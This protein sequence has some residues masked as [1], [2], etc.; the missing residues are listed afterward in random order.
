MRMR[1]DH[2]SYATSHDK[3]ID[4]V[5]R[6]G[7][8]VGAT[9]VDGGIHPGFGTRNFILPLSNGLY[10]EVVCPLDHPAVDSTP[11][12]QM[13][14]KK[15]IEG[16]GWL[17]WVVSTKDISDIE[18]RLGRKAVRGHRKKPNGNDLEWLQVGVIATID[19][20]Q[21]PFFV[22]WVSDIHPSN[23]FSS[24]IRLVSIEIAGEKEKIE[25]WLGTTIESVLGEVKVSWVSP[26]DLTPQES[27]IVAI[28]L[29]S[30]KGLI[31][32]D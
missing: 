26:D 22:Q 24:D 28:Q 32:L 8:N 15:S 5:Q 17:T 12:G 10:I 1:L 25:N 6:L 4:V 20:Y 7:S 23:D 3:L 16:G 29:Q 9:F 13:V 27:G 21:L 30:D 11:F 18:S 19:D 14:S 2:I 31:R